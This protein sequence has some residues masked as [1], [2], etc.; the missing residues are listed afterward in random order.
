MPYANG[1]FSVIGLPDGI[2]FKPYNY[3]SYQLQKIMESADKIQFVL[4]TT[5]GGEQMDHSLLQAGIESQPPLEDVNS[6]LTKVAGKDA[7]DRVIAEPEARIEEEEIEVMDLQITEEER[8]LLYNSCGNYFS[9]DAWFAVG[10]NMRHSNATE[11]LLL[12]VYTTAEEKFWLFRSNDKP[13]RI[14]KCLFSTKIR[15]Q[16]LDLQGNGTYRFLHDDVISGKNLIR[17]AHGPIYFTLK[18]SQGTNFTLPATFKSAI[19]KVLRESE[20][21]QHR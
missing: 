8:D 19:L 20:L 21:V 9:S 14:S 1:G 13:S 11:N 5:D 15:G 4:H 2:D 3:G 18:Q 6:L 16:W 12:P 10:Q 17:S 7:A